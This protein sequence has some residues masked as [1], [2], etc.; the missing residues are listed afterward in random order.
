[1]RVTRLQLRNFRNYREA[2]LT[3][4]ARLTVLTGPNAQGKTNVLEALH[5][6]CLGRS[7]RTAHDRELI[8]WEADKAAVRIQVEQRD[9]THE[10]TI[11]LNRQDARRKQVRVGGALVGRIGELM[12]H[13]HGILFSPEDMAIVKEGPSE[14]RRFLDMELSQLRPVVFY[15]LQRYVR[16]LNH[17]NNLLREMQ[18][19]PALSSTLEDWDAQ[20]AQAGA[21]LVA[22]RRSYSEVLAKAALLNHRAISG[23]GE[24]LIVR[25][26]TQIDGDGDEAALAERF[27][28]RLH[29]ARQ[30]DIRR[31]TT[32]VGPHRDDVK[33]LLGDRE[34]RTF[35]S[36]G[37]QRTIVLA[38]KL[39]E[40]D[41]VLAERGEAP[42]LLLDDVMSEL[43][44]HRRQRLV[45]RIAGV[46]TVVTCTDL[47][48]LGGAQPGAVYDVQAGSLKPRRPSEGG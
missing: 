3:P 11:S 8:A 16:T 12:G 14:R 37:Q 44:P 25:Y 41:V 9:G 35:G 40:L 26:H 28:Q 47:S 36:Q 23:G 19:K 38:L 29:A 43:D 24:A 2:D 48:D 20:L 10:V 39:A 42:V 33:L 15:A 4:D 30:E 5:L 22:H 21:L 1:M 7:H 18:R 17:R 34:A 46:Q 6:C 31:A 27:L 32:T 45:E 13:F